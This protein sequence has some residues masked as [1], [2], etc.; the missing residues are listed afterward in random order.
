ML[1]I[2][3]NFFLY[4]GRLSSFLLSR[5]TTATSTLY[6]WLHLNQLE[7]C[8]SIEKKKLYTISNKI[9]HFFQVIRSVCAENRSNNIDYNVKRDTFSY[10]TRNRKHCC[11]LSPLERTEIDGQVVSTT[12]ALSWE[13]TNKTVGH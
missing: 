8:E 12:I 1:Y 10:G 11:C 9:S 6:C 7:Q 13:L 4:F 2:Y 3:I 5:A